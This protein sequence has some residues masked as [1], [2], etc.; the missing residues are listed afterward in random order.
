MN[1]VVPKLVEALAGIKINDIS[2]NGWHS[3]AISAFGDLYIWGWNSFGQLGIKVFD[4]KKDT[5]TSKIRHK[6]PTVYALPQ[7]IDFDDEM[8]VKNVA[9]GSKH[10][11]IMSESNEVYATGWNKYGQLGLGNQ[12][13][14]K[15]QHSYIES[16]LFVDKFT[17]I[18]NISFDDCIIKCGYMSSFLI[19][20]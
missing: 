8:N 10:T 19:K 1:E 16:E 12:K 4:E 5:T 7:L 9:C 2:A 13:E 14:V 15:F 6:N 3:A 11:L 18:E 20:Q 17:K